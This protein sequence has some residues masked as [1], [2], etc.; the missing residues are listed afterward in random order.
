VICDTAEDI[1]RELG[2]AFDG[3]TVTSDAD[4]SL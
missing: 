2:G 4:P 3:H 1:T